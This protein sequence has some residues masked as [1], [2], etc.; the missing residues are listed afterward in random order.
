MN[1]ETP[2]SPSSNASSRKPSGVD[3]AQLRQL[4]EADLDPKTRSPQ[5]EAMGESM[6]KFLDKPENVEMLRATFSAIGRWLK[7]LQPALV[8]IGKTAAFVAD[9]VE[10]LP[11]QFQAAVVGLANQGWFYDPEMDWS[12]ILSIQEKVEA[13]KHDEIDELMASHFE[14]RLDAIEARLCEA[15]PRRSPKIKSA[16]DAHRRGAYDLSILAFLAQSDGVC[17]ELRGGFFFLNDLKRRRPETAAYV[18]ALASDID[19][20]IHLALVE[21]IPLKRKM[22][23]AR[24]QPGLNRHAVMHGES[25][26]YDTKTNSL[27]SISLLNYIALGLDLGESSAKGR[28]LAKPA[29]QLIAAG[30]QMASS[31]AKMREAG[32]GPKP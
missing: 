30:A 7:P 14:P 28:A 25:L 12:L 6:R 22:S 21:E 19:R 20:I 4:T 2:L 23:K 5:I 9:M 16:F 11:G 15:L 13:G 10:R 18:E 31:K 32:V 26:D 27:R 8:A 17:A 24:G 29:G 1:E 3:G